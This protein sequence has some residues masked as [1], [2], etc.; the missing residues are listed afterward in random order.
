MECCHCQLPYFISILL[1]F[2]H[3]VDDAYRRAMQ[4]T[5]GTREGYQR[6]YSTPPIRPAVK[7]TKAPPIRG[8]QSMYPRDC[9]DA[10]NR[11]NRGELR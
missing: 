2:D 7:P 8:P 9:T 5:G 6:A 10:L 3:F 4:Y 1:Y 11:N